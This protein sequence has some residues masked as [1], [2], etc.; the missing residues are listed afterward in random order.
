MFG[1]TRRAQLR[2]KQ[3]RR[4]EAELAAAKKKAEEAKATIEAE[5]ETTQGDL[6]AKDPALQGLKRAMIVKE[7]RFRQE[8]RDLEEEFQTEREPAS[9]FFLCF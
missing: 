2:L 7:D 5:F 1:G 6:K 3:Q 9:L 4:K 8:I